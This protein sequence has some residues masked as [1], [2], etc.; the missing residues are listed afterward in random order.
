MSHHCKSCKGNFDSEYMAEVGELWA[1][2][3]CR[4]E[5]LAI[6]R[7]LA[8]M[9][10]S[11][12]R[13]GTVTCPLCGEHSDDLWRVSHLSDCLWLRAQKFREKTDDNP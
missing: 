2:E 3:T 12:N 7:E 9:E 5:L 13:R 4:N 1:C 6:V 8:G 10:M 11:E